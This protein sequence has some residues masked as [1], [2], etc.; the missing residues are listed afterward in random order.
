MIALTAYIPPMN[1]RTKVETLVN[2][3]VMN[4]FFTLCMS[5]G[6]ES[7][8]QVIFVMLLLTGWDL[9]AMY[10]CLLD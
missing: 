9:M 7:L 5:R 10:T 3:I 4:V 2:F 1:N 6:A 8:K